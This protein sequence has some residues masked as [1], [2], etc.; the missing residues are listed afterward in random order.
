MAVTQVAWAVVAVTQLAAVVVAVTQVAWAVVVAVTQLAWAEAVAVTQLAW[1]EA[2]D[3][4]AA[5]VEAAS[6]AVAF[7]E[8]SLAV[9]STVE[10]FTEDF[11][12]DF[13]ECVCRVWL[14]AL[15]RRILSLRV[16]RLLRRWRLLHRPSPRDDTL[17]LASSS[18]PSLRMNICSLERPAA[19][20]RRVCLARNASADL[21]S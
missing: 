6:M 5:W 18:R 21:V 1:A 3:T 4:E 8:A 10:D 15:L 13:I 12:A 14:W 17:R 2:V 19:S 7:M 11:T 9:G 20:T 16:Q